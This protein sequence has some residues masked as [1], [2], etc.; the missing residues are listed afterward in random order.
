MPKLP[1]RVSRPWIQKAERRPWMD[2]PAEFGDDPFYHSMAWRNL[3]N[4][5]IKKHPLCAECARVGRTVPGK[6]VDHI[7]ARNHGGAELSESNL[8]TLCESCHNRKRQGEKKSHHN[9]SEQ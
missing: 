9:G 3:R 2:T 6:V 5:F 7:Q 1:D 8:Q 4:L